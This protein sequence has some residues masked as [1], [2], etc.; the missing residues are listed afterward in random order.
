MATQQILFTVMPRG[1]TQ[2]AHP[3]PVSVYVAPR[4]TGA[5]RLVEFPDL[6]DWTGRLVD[7]GLSLTFSANAQTLT[8]PVDASPLHL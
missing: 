7:R 1:I 3:L 5:D 6:L 8:V 4:L 2:N